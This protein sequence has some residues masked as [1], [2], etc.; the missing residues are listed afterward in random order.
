MAS[1]KLCVRFVQ[2]AGPGRYGDGNG[3]W[4]SVSQSGTRRWIY[5]FTLRGKTSEYGLGL[6]QDVSLAAAREAAAKARKLVLEGKSP[7]VARR[8]AKQREKG[9]P[10]F[11]AMT[12]QYIA[13]RSAEW[14]SDKHRA[15][16]VMTM[17]K[18]CA[19]LRPIPVNE[20]DT[21]LIVNTLRPIWRATPET[22]Y[23]LRGRI[24]MVID[25]ARVL[26]FIDENK[27][28]PARWRGHLDKL[29]P[30]RNKMM[31]KHHPALDYEDLPS[32]IT[33][34]RTLPSTGARAL[35]FTILTAARSGETFGAT[36]D[37]IDFNKK[38]WTIKPARMKAGRQHK[39]P[40][41]PRALEIL[42]K[43][44]LET[45]AYCDAKATSEIESALNLY[46]YIFPG[47]KR[48]NPL[49]TM[50]MEMIMRRIGLDKIA[51]PHGFR[52]TF[53]DWA[54]D[55]TNFSREVAEAALAHIV[56]DR[57]EQA[58][59]RET[60]FAKRRDLMEAWGAY[61][62]LNE[63]KLLKFTKEAG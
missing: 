29:L 44:R 50:S 57:S 55:K 1:E 18:Y 2:S 51:T 43:Q 38:T 49:S 37:E 22:A 27:V 32:F 20:I 63:E 58:Y 13:D 35:E 7:V 47:R 15:Q 4:L 30:R 46:K 31:R 34:L 24:E 3:L 25:V 45:L 52:S 56:G 60:A 61:C 59:R 12:D 53:R 5:R 62:S 16:W 36:W 23:R 21:A 19:R 10:S 26:G 41:C 39:V 14:K 11:G 48:T 54:G 28:N 6:V 17:T 42:E 9:I 33:Q 8:I 40:L